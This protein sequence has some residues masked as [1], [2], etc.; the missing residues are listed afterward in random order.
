MKKLWII[1]L[2]L[3]A[4]GC[5]QAPTQPD[6]EQAAQA[7]MLEAMKTRLAKYAQ[8][9]VDQNVPGL[10]ESDRAVMDKFLQAAAI[11]D[12]LFWEQASA[13]GIALRDE[14]ATQ[15]NELAQLQHHFL[16]INKAPYDRQ[17][18]N[19]TFIGDK[20]RPEG[21]TFWPEDLS[22][23][24]LE[25]YVAAHPEEKDALFSL[26]SVVRREEDKLVAIPYHQLHA[27]KL[28]RAS[29][30]LNE[31]A[32]M[33]DNASLKTY[34]ELRAK[35][36]L[37]DDFLASDMA[38]MDLTDNTLD[39]VIGPIEPYEDGLMNLKGAYE[40]Y[41]LVKDA[42]A[43]AE[44]AAYIDAMDEMQAAL[45]I[46]A[47]FKKRAVKLGSSVA[48][49]TLVYAAGDCDAGTKTIA[50]SLPNDERVRA[51][52]G[53]RKI[54]LANAIMAKYEKILKPIAERM[55]VAEQYPLVDGGMFFS[56]VLLH[57]VSHSLGNDFV[58][59]ANGRPTRT[60]VDEALKNHSAAI[61]ECKAD[62]GGL[63]SADEMI[64]MG[65]FSEDQRMSMYAT[66]L[67]GIFRSVRF[68]ASSAH[69]IAN[70]IELNWMLEK[71]GIAVNE[72]GRW[73]LELEPFKAALTELC[74]ELLT[75]QHTGDYA[76]AE[77]LVAKY[78]TLPQSL[79]DQLAA[80]NDIPVDIEFVW[81]K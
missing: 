27:E 81:K 19:E 41:V 45:P 10:S 75:I 33:T 20:P 43:S 34:L 4:A 80:L 77:A 57:E 65:R 47:K 30:L 53:A 42:A 21:A 26:T 31:A 49:F 51:A 72:E 55:L 69:G 32:E 74:A 36:L 29:T 17:A 18:N 70:A 22:R 58:L 6:A 52:K 61:E 79:A 68:G 37:D 44:L 35:A 14:L 28:Q 62:I 15:S 71:G 73:S 5:N 60:K 64:K 59:D 48:T 63:Y 12:E 8:V 39:L 66:F 67:A 11:M 2:I 24:E 23:E 46:D 54:M 16:M 38:W 9:E 76:R 13:E 7:A 50:I 25:A 78:G 3:L 56:N 1:A 40:A